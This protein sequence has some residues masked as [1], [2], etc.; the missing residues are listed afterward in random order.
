MT[1][2]LVGKETGNKDKNEGVGI[3]IN[4][5]RGVGVDTVGQNTVPMFGYFRKSGL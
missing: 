4:E 1:V 2:L 5:D 3:G